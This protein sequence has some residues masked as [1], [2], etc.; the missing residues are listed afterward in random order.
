MSAPAPDRPPL[1]HG[2]RGFVYV[3]IGCAFVG[4]G[5]L[6]AAL[7]LLPTTPFLLLASYFF[8]RSSPRLHQWLM[9]SPLFGPFLRD[10]HHHRG[11]RPAVKLTAVATVFVAVAASMFWGNLSGLSMS[12]LIVLAAVGLTIVIR[13][14]VVREQSLVEHGLSEPE[15]SATELQRK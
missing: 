3:T 13:L 11:V 14:P 10:W 4:L 15:A 9:R 6:G 2:P 5:A 12:L 7:P 1:V 8:V